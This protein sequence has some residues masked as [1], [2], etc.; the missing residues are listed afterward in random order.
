MM[1]FGLYWF[2]IALHW[3]FILSCKHVIAPT[4]RRAAR[5]SRSGQETIYPIEAALARRDLN[6]LLLP[7]LMLTFLSTA[8][9][10]R[11]RSGQGF[12]LYSFAVTP[13]NSWH[14]NGN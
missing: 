10:G 1:G 13:M 9:S 8:A 12:T 14:L 3:V 2:F 6:M 7:V 11:I 4:T 5:Q